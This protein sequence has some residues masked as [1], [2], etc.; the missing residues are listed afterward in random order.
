MYSTTTMG[1]NSLVIQETH[2]IWV[3]N[4]KMFAHGKENYDKPRNCTKKQRHHFADKDPYKAMVFPVVMC[5][6]Q[7]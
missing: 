6:C 1:F 5:G 3:W 2:E 7:S 4:E